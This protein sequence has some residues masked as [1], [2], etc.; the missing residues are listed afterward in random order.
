[1]VDLNVLIDLA[2]DRRPW[3]AAA[4]GRP[5][6]ARS[7]MRRPRR[8]ADVFVSAISFP[9]LF[10]LVERAAGTVAAFAAV[11]SMLA[12]TRV[13]AVDAAVLASARAMSGD[14][15]EDNL[16]VASAVAAGVDL[17]VT[18]DPSGFRRSPVPAVDAGEALR[19]L[20]VR[21]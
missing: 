6:P 19:R 9:T 15:F 16:Q 21:P 18:R 7:S 1:L 8:R 12:A 11:D 2:L 3:A 14:D 5:T 10:Y 17:I 20:L 13:A 4:R